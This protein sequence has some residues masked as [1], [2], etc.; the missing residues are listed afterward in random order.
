M[1]CAIL[2]DYQNAALS[3]ADWGSLTRQVEITVFNAPIGGAA[4]IAAALADFEIIC[5]MRERTPFTAE[6]I[7]ALPKLR[8]IATSGARNAAIDVAAA[9]ARG[10][11]VCGTDSAVHPTAELV[12]A[13]ML[14]FARK[15][16]H[17]NARLKA[18]AVWQ[19]TIG[20]DLSGK[21]LGVLG[22]GRLGERVARIAAAFEMNVI[23]WSENLTAERCAE[24]GVGHVSKTDLFRAS[25]FLSIHLQLSQRTRGLVGAEALA[26]MRPGAILVNTSRGPIV[27]EGALLD[28]VRAGRI[29]GACL[30]VYDE[31]PLPLE[32]P[33][34]AEPKIQISPHLGY[35]TEA[36]LRLFYGQMVE[37]IRAFAEGNPVRVVA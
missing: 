16:G 15:V 9:N 18:G 30:D 31:E 6:I 23:A 32:H 11:S 5:L 2:D 4:E 26:L 12:F 13:H 20:L 34:R 36:N 28:A 17:E 29:A 24:L 10:V 25:D 35:V 37:D 8:L 7:G 14:E 3:M 1:R 21:T 22:L 33:Y 19:E 27:E